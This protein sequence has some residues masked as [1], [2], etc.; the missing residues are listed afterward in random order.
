MLGQPQVRSRGRSHYIATALLE[1][2]LLQEDVEYLLDE[3]G[4]AL[5]RFI[6]GRDRLMGWD[7][8]PRGGEGYMGLWL[9]E[10]GQFEVLTYPPSRET[11]DQADQAG[12]GVPGSVSAKKKQRPPPPHRR[13]RYSKHEMTEQI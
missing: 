4:I 10:A 6:D 12:F 3:Q 11:G 13:I 8:R 2:L 7:H 5:C 9:L 1:R